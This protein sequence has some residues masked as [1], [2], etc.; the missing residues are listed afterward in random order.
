MYVK[1]FW[2]AYENQQKWRGES[3]REPFSFFTHDFLGGLSH[4]V[5]VHW[6]LEP[7]RIPAAFTVGP[8]EQK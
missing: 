2:K 3:L 5:F 8:L 4:C 6:P 7:L 1:N